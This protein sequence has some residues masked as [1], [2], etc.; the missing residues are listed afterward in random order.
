MS[1]GDA[2]EHA[3]FGE[4]DLL[5]KAEQLAVPGLVTEPRRPP[6]GHDLAEQRRHLS[7]HA[8]L[9]PP[10]GERRAQEESG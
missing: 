8:L 7:C 10:F 6:V 4:L 9:G 5:D 2:G 3:I 1:E